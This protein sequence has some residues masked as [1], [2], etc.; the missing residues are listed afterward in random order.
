VIEHGDRRFSPM[1][2]RQRIGDQSGCLVFMTGKDDETS[3]A[4][5]RVA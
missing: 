1:L 5:L 2:Y 3:P 4:P